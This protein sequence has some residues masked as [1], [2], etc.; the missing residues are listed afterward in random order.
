M[1]EI[2]NALVGMVQEYFKQEY[3][4]SPM[5]R[6]IHFQKEDDF[7]CAVCGKVKV[8]FDISIGI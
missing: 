2:K 6:N 3:G 1:K 7:L 8:Y 4:F 5:Y